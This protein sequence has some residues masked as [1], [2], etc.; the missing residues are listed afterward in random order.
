M[1]PAFERLNPD[2]QA[3]IDGM[4]NNLLS[5]PQRLDRNLLLDVLITFQ[6]HEQGVDRVTYHAEKDFSGGTV[7]MDVKFD[8]TKPL[9]DWFLIEI[10]DHN[11]KVLRKEH[12]SGDEVWSH[13][14]D[15]AGIS[16]IEATT[17]PTTSPATAETTEPASTEAD[18]GPSTRPATEP[19]E[20]Q[21]RRQWMEI[22]C[23]QILAA[24]QPARR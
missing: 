2:D 23:K 6:L 19:Y 3:R 18:A 11:N 9:E 16:V 7:L 8:R 21:L 12:Y 10:R 13:S 24:T 22:R 4:W 20:A 17:Q 1:V 14:Y 5:D 15:L